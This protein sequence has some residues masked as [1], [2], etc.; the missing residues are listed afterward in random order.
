MTVYSVTLTTRLQV[1]KVHQVGTR[2]ICV[3]VLVTFVCVH[4]VILSIN[5]TQFD[6]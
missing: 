2:N 3:V 6:V 4:I 1:L 5:E